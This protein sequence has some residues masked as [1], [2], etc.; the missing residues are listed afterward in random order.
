MGALRRALLRHGDRP[1]RYPQGR[2]RLPAARP[3]LSKRASRLHAGR[4]RRAPAGHAIRRSAHALPHARIVD[5]DADRAAITHHPAS[6]PH[7]PHR[8]AHHRLRHLHLRLDRPTQKASRSLRAASPID[9]LWMREQYPQTPSDIVLSRTAISFDAA[10]W[11]IWL[12]L[13]TGA[14]LSIAPTAVTRDPSQLARHIRTPEHYDRAVR[15]LAAGAD[16]RCR[17]AGRIASSQANALSAGRRYPGNHSASCRHDHAAHRWSISTGRPKRRS[18]SRRGQVD[19]RRRAARTNRRPSMPI[20]CP[21]WNTRVYVLDDGLRPVPAGV[22]GELYV[23][24]RVWRGAIWG[25]RV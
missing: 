24:G 4:R 12:P 1:P 21:I 2:R 5:L 9:M 6:A 14:A 10:E 20:G 17:P 15:S 22:G 13:L 7:R 19:R 16:A 3:R 23:A 11:E 18:R 8:P 25:V